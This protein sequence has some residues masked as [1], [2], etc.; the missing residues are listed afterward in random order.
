MS[1]AIL[2]LIHRSVARNVSVNFQARCR[3]LLWHA[4]LAR[5]LGAARAYCGIE[6]ATWKSSNEFCVGLSVPV[7][8]SN[9]CN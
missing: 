6:T 9:D 4:N 1:R 7:P 8:W 3:L 2:K 5:D